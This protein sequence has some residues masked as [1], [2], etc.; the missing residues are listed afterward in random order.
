MRTNLSGLLLALLI[1]AG[2]CAIGCDDKKAKIPETTY[3][4]PPPPVPSGGGG[5]GAGPD[6]KASTID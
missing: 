3:E 6:K 5:G 4:L 1:V 2:L